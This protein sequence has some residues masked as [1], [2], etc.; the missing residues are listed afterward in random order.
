LNRREFA[1]A[2]GVSETAIAKN[3]KL[4]RVRLP[5]GSLF[6]DPQ[7]KQIADYINRKSN[8]PNRKEVRPEPEEKKQTPSS[9]PKEPETIPSKIAQPKNKIVK[10]QPIPD[11]EEVDEYNLD[12]ELK[13]EK[14]LTSRQARKEKRRDLIKREV[15]KAYVGQIAA[16]HSLILIPLGGRISGDIAREFGIATP[17]KIIRIE[18]IITEESYKVISMIKRKNSDF[19]NS[20]KQREENDA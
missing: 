7:N 12:D 5:D 8:K 10:R 4:P 2:A 11:D 1:E 3:K 14:I 19:I 15:V 9:I 18:E 20:I 16:V 13:K 17:E 6:F